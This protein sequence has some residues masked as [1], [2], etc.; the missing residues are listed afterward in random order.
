MTS[1]EIRERK[2]NLEKRKYKNSSTHLK[3]KFS[4][5]K[6]PLPYFIIKDT[7]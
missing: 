3:K 7:A 5:Q 6:M 2:F 1:Y 4:G